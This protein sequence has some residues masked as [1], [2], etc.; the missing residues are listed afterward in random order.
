VEQDCSFLCPI[1]EG[2]VG[3]DWGE[4]TEADVS[5]SDLEKEPVSG[6]RFAPVAPDAAKAKNFEQ[7]KKSFTDLLFRTRTVEIFK[8]PGLKEVSQP[9]ESERD[10]R[11]RLQQAAR[12]QR[13]QLVAKLREKYAPKNAVLQD[14]IRRAQQAQQRESEQASQQ[15]MQTAISFGATVLGALF[16]RKALGA[17]TIGKATTAMRGVGRTM[18]ES[19]DVARAAETVEA[20]QQQLSELELKCQTEVQAIESKVD[21]LTEQLETVVVK[22]KKTN[23]TVRVLALAWV[24]Y[25]ELADGSV[26]AAW[27]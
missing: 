11:V 14:R 22:P 25:W 21:P 23:I 4:A 18:K 12:E 9:N 27:E 20:A 26:K 3:V 8:S 16:G 24:P 6:A 17:G 5:D 7:W 10:F 1:D 19:K 2:V 15:K 13:D